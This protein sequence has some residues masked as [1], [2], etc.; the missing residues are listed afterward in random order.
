MAPTPAAIFVNEAAGSARTRRA[1]RTV[2]LAQRVL[3]ADVHAVATRDQAELRQW[4]D[5]RIGPY[6]TVVVAGGDGSLGIA[7]NAAAGHDVALGYIPA[8]FGNAAAH[9]LRL[10][11]S[12]EGIAALLAS[13][14]EK[15]ID[16]VRVDGRLALFA[17]VGWDAVVAQRYA[18][19]GAR[20]LR[21]WSEAVLRSWPELTHRYNVRIEAD[22]KPVH[23]GPMELLVVGTTPF[24]G[25]GMV[26]NPGA[27]PD[28]GRLMLRVYEGPAPQLALEAARWLIHVRPRAR[29]IAATQVS[30]ETLDERL[31]PLQ[32][33]GDVIGYRERWRVDLKPAAVRIIGRW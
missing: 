27:R 6:R 32:A 1:R 14:R 24:Y 7:L 26:V 2:E 18:Q 21:G 33:D 29:G 25:R 31:L 4:M 12:P 23:A 10:P 9:L 8:G 19:A 13:G 15:P 30:I 3:N 28:A 11:R 20:R 22:G 5:A 16:L 17:G